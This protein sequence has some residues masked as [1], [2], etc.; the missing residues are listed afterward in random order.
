MPL[1]VHNNTSF[2]SS[3]THFKITFLSYLKI[4]WEC[5]FPPNCWLWFHFRRHMNASMSSV[6]WC[7]LCTMLWKNKERGLGKFNYGNFFPSF[8]SLSQVEKYLK[9]SH[10]MIRNYVVEKLSRKTLR[11][12]WIRCAAVLFPLPSLILISL[13]LSHSSPWSS[14]SLYL[15]RKG[16]M[17]AFSFFSFFACG[18]PAWCSIS[19]HFNW[20]LN[21][22]ATAKLILQCL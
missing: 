6:Q 19:F 16:D 8:W 21:E 7:F 3:N 18:I 4:T 12:L 10:K 2:Q 17:S 13:E 22:R 14:I 11:V 20:D 5:Y 15:E 9:R 1:R